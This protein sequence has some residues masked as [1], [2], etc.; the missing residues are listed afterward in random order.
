[1]CRR[2]FLILSIMFLSRCIY[3]K[4]NS[5][6]K[7]RYPET[8]YYSGFISGH[9]ELNKEYSLKW[10]NLFCSKIKDIIENSPDEYYLEIRGKMDATELSVNRE[11][12]SF[13]RAES[14]RQL[15]LSFGIPGNKMKAIADPDPDEFLGRDKFDPENR[16]VRFRLQAK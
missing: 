8:V 11:K 2:A 9:S 10:C 14:V 4:N 5:L 12:I 16:T 6:D 15:L 3:F 13:G 1:M 7:I